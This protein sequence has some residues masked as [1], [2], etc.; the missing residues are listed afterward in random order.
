MDKKLLM[1]KLI[2]Y[3]FLQKGNLNILIIYFLIMKVISGIIKKKFYEIW[4][5]TNET[6][7]INTIE[8]FKIYDKPFEYSKIVFISFNK[9]NNF[10]TFFIRII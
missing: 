3:L 6:A 2:I 5:L 9:R 4:F 8:S 1:L 7:N 10:C